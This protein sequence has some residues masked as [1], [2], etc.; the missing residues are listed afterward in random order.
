MENNN[1]IFDMIAN[2]SYTTYTTPVVED[3]SQKEEEFEL[4]SSIDVNPVEDQNAEKQ[5]VEEQSVDQSAVEQ[6]EVQQENEKEQVEEVAQIPQAPEVPEQ[7][8]TVESTQKV[9]AKRGRKPKAKVVEE[10]QPI[11]ETDE[12]D[13]TETNRI[14]EITNEIVEEMIDD[15][16]IAVKEEPGTKKTQTKNVNIDYSKIDLETIVSKIYP[17]IVDENWDNFKER[18]EEKLNKTI[19]DEN[20]NDGS[21]RIV[22]AAMCS[23]YAEV[24]PVK[25]YYDSLY[26]SCVHKDMGYISRQIALN[27][28]NGKTV[29][30]KKLNGQKS[31]ES[32][33]LPGT[34]IDV[35]F[36]NF[37]LVVDE[38][39]NYINNIINRLN[40][41]RDCLVGIQA[42]RK[43]E[44]EGA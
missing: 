5:I 14:T 35:N 29:A 8:E 21:I 32:V 10:T 13:S 34:K 1:D 26:N 31:C 25:A 11:E 12:K 9:P 7:K 39:R 16:T 36:N 23:I 37:A 38:R 44:V 17:T 28:D 15:G 18:M 40:F 30:E 41:V 3:A 24:S 33:R 22:L 20:I 27:S 4:D 19:F 6:Y 42:V 43:R 2:L